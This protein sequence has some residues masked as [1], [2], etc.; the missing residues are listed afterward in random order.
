TT[1]INT[2]INF[3]TNPGCCRSVFIGNYFGDIDK[4]SCGICDYCLSLKKN[5]IDE[6]SFASIEKALFL[7]V[8]KAPVSTAHIIATIGEEKKE[9]T[10][11]VIRFLESENRLIMNEDGTIQL[12]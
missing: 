9:N 10:W 5:K 6:A 12:V 2:L 8:G 7:L 3:A 11:E 4:D 1:R